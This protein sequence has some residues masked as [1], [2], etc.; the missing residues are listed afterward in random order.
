MVRS[1]NI[2]RHQIVATEI[3]PLLLE[4]VDFLQ[5]LQCPGI[6]RV[7][8]LLRVGGVQDSGSSFH[9]RG[10]DAREAKIVRIPDREVDQ[11][12]YLPVEVETEISPEA[13]RV[14]YDS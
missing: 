11:V 6:P 2:H 5:G 4:V 10:R 1:A 7:H 12:R 3:G 13:L 9:E 8:G 14:S